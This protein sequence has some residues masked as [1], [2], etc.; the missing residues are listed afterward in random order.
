MISITRVTQCYQ[1]FEIRKLETGHLLRGTDHYL[2]EATTGYGEI[3]AR[4]RT[5]NPNEPD[6]TGIVSMTRNTAIDRADL[7]AGRLFG[8]E[9]QSLN[10]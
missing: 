4:D 5:G 6:T 3:C 10:L 1:S 8:S 7:A 9:P 2:G